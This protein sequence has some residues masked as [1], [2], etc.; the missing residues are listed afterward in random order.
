VPAR[1]QSLGRFRTS[2]MRAEGI[3]G[4]VEVWMTLKDTKE[5]HTTG[6]FPVVQFN[7]SQVPFVVFATCSKRT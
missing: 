7:T 1:N 4:Y 6:N 5:S 3:I 2:A